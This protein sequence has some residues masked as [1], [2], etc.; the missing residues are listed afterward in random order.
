M[1]G[2]KYFRISGK[3]AQRKSA[4]PPISYHIRPYAFKPEFPAGIPARADIISFTMIFSDY[5][6]ESYGFI[7]FIMNKFQFNS[8]PYRLRRSIRR[9][10][11]C[12]YKNY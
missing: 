5:V 6:I 3:R 7:L 9:H 12:K 2:I 11:I 8:N 4:C 10:E 1:Q